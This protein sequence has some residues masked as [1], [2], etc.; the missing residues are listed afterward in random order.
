MHTAALAEIT[1]LINES[2]RLTYTEP[3]ASLKLAEDASRLASACPE[4][5][6]A[7]SAW[8]RYGNMLFAF[9]QIP[10]G[11]M[12]HLKALTIAETEDLPALRGELLQELA[13]AYYTQGDFDEAISYWAD[14]LT[15]DANGFSTETRIYA[16]IGLG[17]VYF[18]HEQF[19]M[20]LAQHLNAQALTT[21]QMT[22]ELRARVWINLAADQ[23]ALHLWQDANATL[24]LAWPLA[25]K[26]GHKEYQGEILVYRAEVALGLGDTATAWDFVAQAEQLRRVWHWGETSE[27]MLKSRILVAEGRLD[28]ALK[29]IHHA[30]DRSNET[31][32]GHKTFKAHHLLAQIYRQLGDQ[33]AA[34]HH[35]RLYQEA[36]KRIV[37]TSSYNKLQALEQRLASGI[38][39]TSA[40]HP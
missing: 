4:P 21:D 22:L 23:I 38:S 16:Y 35:H 17:Q 40:P 11:Q 39:P 7:A 26:D 34:E 18:A 12:A 37:S 24:D 31:G 28:A 25:L 15:G 27:L 1:H 8:Q 2:I 32:T 33:P 3:H 19:P 36:Y 6:L 30:L 14:C 10:E 20:A 13:G 5:L 9:G 29:A